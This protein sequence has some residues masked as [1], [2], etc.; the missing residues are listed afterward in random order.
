M[1]LG[2]PYKRGIL[3]IGLAVLAAGC[4]KQERNADCFHIQALCMEGATKTLL[5]SD[6]IESKVTS[7]VLAA[8]SNGKLY[9]TAFYA[10]DGSSLALTLENRQPYTVYALVNT[11][12]T[13]TLFPEYESEVSNLT[14]RLTSYDSG[15]D[16]VN[17]RGIP[18]AGSASA[19][20]GGGGVSI[21]VKRL[22]AK[23]R[24]TIKCDWPGASVL[25]GRICNMNAVLKPFGTSA[26]TST[27]DSFTYSP[28][29]HEWTGG[30]SATLIFYVPENM[31]G[32]VSGILS[33]NDKTHEHNAAVASMRDCL[34]YMET[35]VSGNWL[36][37]G[38]ITYR[39]YLGRNSTDNFDIER[40][41]IYSWDITYTEDN[42]S[43]D[44]WKMD[45]SLS[46]LRT[47]SVPE[48][49]FLVPG[50]K[51]RL[52]DYVNTNMPYSSIGWTIGPVS[53]G[54]DL[55]GA[56]NN[57]DNLEGLSFTV[58]D[59]LPPLGYG[60][61]VIS[62]GPVS[63]PRG[64][65]GGR[66]SVFVADQAIAFRN[67]LHGPV[68]NMIDRYASG[69]DKYFVTPGK[70]TDA[71]VDF[72]VCYNDDRLGQTVSRP[73]PGLGGKR[74]QVSQQP[75]DGI[76][77]QIIGDTGQDYDL[78]NYSVAADVLPGDYPISATTADGSKDDAY[79]HVNDTRTLRWVDRSSAVP[80]TSAGILACRLIA[81]NKLVLIIKPGST[82]AKAGTAFTRNNTP[83]QFTASDRSL[84]SGAVQGYAGAAF[85]GEALH[86]GNYTGKIGITYDGSLATNRVYNVTAGNKTVSGILTLVPII[87][88]DLSDKERHVIT[89]KAKNGYDANTTHDIEAVI[90][91]KT[92]VSNELALSPAISRV[93]VGS[94]I[95]FT[96]TLYS[97]WLMSSGLRDFSP[98]VLSNSNPGLTW[99]GAPGG[100]FTATHP[101]NYRITATYTGGITAYAD[102]EVTA[103]DIDVSGEW[104]NGGSV[105]LD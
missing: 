7:T 2:I 78:V 15:D 42:L 82:Y 30:S 22:L 59:A 34:T 87:T 88:S 19:I 65:L 10:G 41:C 105:V 9:R 72:S 69:G 81:D 100:V 28:E 50:E 3:T 36:Y 71:Q 54:A 20:G 102:I 16:C 96:A 64:G 99:S 39:S 37:D 18:M 40:N 8:Y 11:G 89:I 32:N 14:Y 95:M 62:I 63:N 101:G 94:T 80:S 68:F 85:E 58:D 6:G 23:V 21:G 93:T 83:F 86:A 55:V 27:D 91:A 56:V 4:S 49:L 73:L 33:P 70:D 47:L 53:T 17:S 38:E 61:R 92:G 31:Q 76:S 45:N 46:D 103:S 79:L 52:G 84:K 66:T 60:S 12:D 98:A 75:F 77:G 48:E 26:M 104:E 24:A 74:W 1:G 25:S 97:I 29:I 67:T 5:N 51:V 44:E 43:H 13:R 57:M 35:R 90:R